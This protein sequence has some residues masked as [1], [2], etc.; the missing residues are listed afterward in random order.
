M[1]R[2][3]LTA[4]AIL[5]ACNPASEV[6]IEASK[7]PVESAP[8]GAYMI[9]RGRG[10]EPAALGPY[11]AALPSI[12][13]KY[14]GRYVAFDTD[15]D[16]AEGASADQALIISAW[17]SKA[18]ARAFWDSP[19]YREAIKLRDGVGTFDVVIVGALPQ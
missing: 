4:A 3:V 19:E 8:I 15:I 11:A 16:V 1:K 10:Y 17:P 7:D 9:V 18:A 2:L 14:G 13:E 5:S 6:P 12:Y